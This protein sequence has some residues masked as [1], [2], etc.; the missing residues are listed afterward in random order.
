MGSGSRDQTLV[1]RFRGKCLYPLSHLVYLGSSSTE[2]PDV[3][4]KVKCCLEFA[5]AYTLASCLERYRMVG[6]VT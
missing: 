6:T 2:E 5:P 4:S 1:I 3:P